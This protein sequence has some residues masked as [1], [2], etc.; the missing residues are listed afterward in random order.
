[1]SKPLAIATVMLSLVSTPLMAR[2]EGIADETAHQ[3]MRDYLRTWSSNAGVN[4]RSMT[5]FYADRVVYY[6]KPMSR[7]GVLRDKLQYISTWRERRYSLVPG[8]VSIACNGPRTACQVTG[9][10]RWDRRSVYGERSV[11]AARL[12]LLVTRESGGRIARES[13]VPLQ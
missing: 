11:G 12:G 13:A 10:M 7:S 2:S 9:T 1:M 5:R 8:S 4:P 6:G 3:L